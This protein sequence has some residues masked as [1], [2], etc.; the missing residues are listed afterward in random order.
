MSTLT[1][2]Y[3]YYKQTW[4]V[5]LSP[6][7]HGAASSLVKLSK[8]KIS[9]ISCVHDIVCIRALN[10]RVVRALNLVHG[11]SL[12]V[13]SV[14]AIFPSVFP[15]ERVQPSSKFAPLIG[16]LNRNL[17][18]I[19]SGCGWSNGTCEW[20]HKD[21]DVPELTCSGVKIVEESI[22]VMAI[23]TKHDCCIY[24]SSQYTFFI[25]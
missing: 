22:W 23:N 19:V 12:L 8:S 17:V 18:K 15:G 21:W 14:K 9:T 6:N 2:S 24:K 4:I 10:H 16:M 1:V 13:P 11:P 7:N 20:L 3:N 25:K 5:P